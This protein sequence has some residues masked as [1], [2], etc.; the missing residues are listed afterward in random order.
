[1]PIFLDRHKLADAT[2]HDVAHAHTLD[3]AVQEKHGVSYLTYWFDPRACTAFCL[4][5]APDAE[6][7][8]R[9]HGEAHGMLP[10]E[11]IEV[12]PAM[13]EA[14]LG[15]ISDPKAVL[16]PIEEPASRVIMFTDIVNSTEMTARLGDAG[17]MQIVRAH[18]DLVRRELRAHEGREV[19]HLG[20]GIMASFSDPPKAV[21]CA[22][23][24]QSGVGPIN[25]SIG[26]L[27]QLRIGLHV[28]EPVN[29]SNDLFG[30][31]VQMAARICADA[32]VESVVISQELRDLIGDDFTVT[33]LGRRVLKGF[34]DPAPLYSVGWA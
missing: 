18:D 13:V 20:D 29:E 15:R 6:A 24:I 3:L 2:A 28:G 4:V 31:T 8:I 32:S 25:A 33:P 14:F 22:C 26:E 1:M 27:L 12:D 9:V 5:E 17:A 23:A 34:R 16:Q 30:T 7:A 10:A 21:T 11:I 19:K